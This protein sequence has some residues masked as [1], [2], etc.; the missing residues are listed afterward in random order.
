[1]AVTGQPRFASS[2]IPEPLFLLPAN[3][4]ICPYLVPKHSIMPDLEKILVKAVWKEVESTT[5]VAAALDTLTYATA[6]VG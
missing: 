4:S 5:C 2:F 1:M 3:M 6:C